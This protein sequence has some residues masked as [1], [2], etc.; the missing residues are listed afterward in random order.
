[1]AEGD[2]NLIDPRLS[3]IKEVLEWATE[4]YGADILSV[5]TDVD[6][7]TI[8]GLCGF[9]GNKKSRKYLEFLNSEN[10]GK[11]ESVDASGNREEVPVFLNREI[12]NGLIKASEGRVGTADEM[13]KSIDR[14]KE[15]LN[16]YFTGGGNPTAKALNAKELAKVRS[17]MG[18][19]SE[20]FGFNSAEQ[21]EMFIAA[22]LAPDTTTRL[23]GIPGTGKTTLI[24]CAALMFGNSYGFTSDSDNPQNQVWDSLRSE[25]LRR[26]WEDRRFQEQSYR[27]PFNY[28]LR[29][30]YIPSQFVSAQD[31]NKTN[32]TLSEFKSKTKDFV[33]GQYGIGGRLLNDYFHI[34]QKALQ[35]NGI[36]L[37]AD[38]KGIIPHVSGASLQ[39]YT[40]YTTTNG[41]YKHPP[42]TD[43]EMSEGVDFA[44][45]E[46][47]TT[48]NFKNLYNAY[49]A[50]YDA[51]SK[52]E[53]GEPLSVGNDNAADLEKALL[54][55]NNQTVV[56]SVMNMIK[57]FESGKRSARRFI[58]K[59]YY[60][61]RTENDAGLKRIDSEMR[62]EIGIAKVDKDKRAE[63]LLYGVDITAQERGERTGLTQYEFTPY[64]REI[65]TQPIKFFNEV[66]RSQASVEDA[67][68][69]LI[70]EKE[71]E[72]RGQVFS[73]PNFTAFMDTNPHVGGNDLAFTD[74]IDME[75]MFPSALLDQRYK[76][77]KGSLSAESQAKAT[78]GVE[79]PTPRRRVL[80]KILDG[81]IT[82][83]RYEELKRIWQDT[84]MV[85]YETS[86]Y[87]ALM[88]IAIVSMLFAQRYGVHEPLA[89]VSLD[90][91]VPFKAENPNMITHDRNSGDFQSSLKPLN[92][93][94]YFIDASISESKAYRNDLTKS[95]QAISRGHGAMA[96]MDRVLAF[97]FTNSLAKLSRALAYLRGNAYVTRKEIMDVLPYV[98]GHRI[99]R[100]KGDGGNMEYGIKSEAAS[101]FASGQE[102]VREVIVSGYLERDVDSFGAREM[103]RTG[104]WSQSRWVEWDST[105]AQ[106]R[107]DLASARTYAE[108]EMKMWAMAR[109][110]SG[111]GNPETQSGT[112]D[113]M[114]YL[115]YRLVLMEEMA[116][117][118]PN[119]MLHPFI[120]PEN[121]TRIPEVY[122]KRVEYYQNKISDFLTSTE[123]YAAADA[124]ILRRK[125]ALERW[126]SIEDKLALLNQVDSL[127]D[128][129]TGSQLPDN[130]GPEMTSGDAEDAQAGGNLK[131]WGLYG[132][133]TDELPES[134]KEI[135]LDD[136]RTYLGFP[137]NSF[138][139]GHTWYGGS[140]TGR[141]SQILYQGNT[142]WLMEDAYRGIKNAGGSDGDA[143]SEGTAIYP[144]ASKRNVQQSIILRGSVRTDE[145][146]QN[147]RDKIENLLNEIDQSFEFYAGCELEVGA[148]GKPSEMGLSELIAEINDMV[149]EMNVAT[150]DTDVEKAYIC[151]VGN[152]EREFENP[153]RD[154]DM[155]DE[156][157]L[158]ILGTDED[159]LRLYI[160]FTGDS[161]GK[162][163][164]INF[165]LA[166]TFVHLSEENNLEVVSITDNDPLR[167]ATL[168]ATYQNRNTF[169]DLG[170]MT[171]YAALLFDILAEKYA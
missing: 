13:V 83:L 93:S 147:M 127:I 85:S 150:I 73:S 89:E 160:D 82:P 110:A 62:R 69:G 27:Y 51:A 52:G 25:A 91:A 169:F 58:S 35:D 154:L 170:N 156:T 63:Q 163:V 133:C 18:V 36:I 139:R 8:T 115:I 41:W 80:R 75:L 98:V 44:F 87:N 125:V 168:G 123:N 109:L 78:Q 99:G 141:A 112:G 148:A 43:Q 49:R 117:T 72:Y 88:D 134:F 171:R 56:E 111:D 16:N 153:V 54:Y 53:R 114:P 76:I 106:A 94:G 132:A 97:R 67:I 131:L 5:T 86:G 165:C 142:D 161:A 71:V 96:L 155:W 129:I 122:D 118:E 77:L 120:N 32:F 79:K 136:I 45:Y 146:V 38:E 6:I 17:F 95:I 28:L 66:N 59:V 92:S 157:A 167:A 149:T 31:G 140:N 104:D 101:Q 64:P 21:L 84:K 37:F 42:L 90:F 47:I 3:N 34:A 166:S 108:Y 30:I 20:V 11:V 19:M 24:E 60:D 65:V 23:S 130:F 22:W 138:I 162:Y 137:T 50:A 124:A 9:D 40:E 100:S 57:Q 12:S 116:A 128:G 103:G 74:R 7:N 107:R 2:I 102:F 135:D 119:K 81:E 29:D 159:R 105:I 55:Y 4:K 68:L 113:P 1:M 48:N 144:T 70:A 151:E 15:Q 46:G 164:E 14:L 33:K 126:L 39:D 10:Q 152:R 158:K 26:E 145:E 143:L 121:E 61:A